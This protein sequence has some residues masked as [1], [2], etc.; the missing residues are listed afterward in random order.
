MTGL[1]AW[2][3]DFANTFYK[4]FIREDRYK[5]LISG[6]G[7]TIRVSLIAVTLGILIGLVVALCNLSN[8][9]PL[10]VIGGIYTDVIRGTPSVTQLMIIYFVIFATVNIPKWIIAGI[11]FG[12]NSGA[13]VSE[14]IRAG[15]LS[16]DKGQT[17]AGRSLGLNGYQTMIHIVIPQAVKNIFPALCNEFIV[18]IK[19]TAISGYIGLQDLTMAGNII[20]SN[21][22]QAFL[23]LITVAAVYLV[24]VMILSAGVRKL[25][26]NLKKNERQVYD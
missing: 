19:E 20:R 3:A 15:I 22:Y 5:L 21:T 6:I 12:I 10:K 23:P 26:K 14:I 7:V 2:A 16:V 1:S 4:C 11:A 18:L 9:K 17:E 13:Y 24:I 25:E 8:K